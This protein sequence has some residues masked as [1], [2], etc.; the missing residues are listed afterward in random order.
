MTHAPRGRIDCRVNLVARRQRLQRGGIDLQIV[1]GLSALIRLPAV[2]D[3]E[4]LFRIA[5]ARPEDRAERLA[6]G[7]RRI[8]RSKPRRG[9]EQSLVLL[10]AGGRVPHG[11]GADADADPLHVAASGGTSLWIS[12]PSASDLRNSGS[13]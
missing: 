12:S 10:D 8:R 6:A 2:I 9:D 13:I 4:R 1:G 7:K 5:A 11:R 3:A